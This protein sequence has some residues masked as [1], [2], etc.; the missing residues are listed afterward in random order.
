MNLKPFKGAGST[1]SRRRF[2]DQIYQSVVASRKVGGRN[3]TVDEHQGLGTLIN[4][5]DV[6]ARRQPTGQGGGGGPPP[7]ATGACCED[8]ECS[9]TTESDCEGQWQG[10]D[11]TCEDV[12]CTQATTGACCI[13]EDCTTET[14]GDCTDMGGT[15]QGDDTICDPNPCPDSC[16]CAFTAFDGSGRLF[17]TAT[18]TSTGH[19]TGNICDWSATSVVKCDHGVQSIVSCS[20]SITGPFG[21]Y[22]WVSGGTNYELNNY[23]PNY[24]GPFCGTA[25]DPCIN[26]STC[27]G[28]TVNSATN[29]TAGTG[30]LFGTGGCSVD[31]SDE[32]FPPMMSAFRDD[33]FFRNK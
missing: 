15:Y 27:S 26:A 3:V 17:L 5:A 9:I 30:C 25:N 10:S 22:S 7:V 19:C 28:F 13:G 2:W 8:G 16:S 33:P 21:T 11:T 23:V 32:C 14:P 29:Q 18:V 20:G 24:S 12:D 6:G 4:V 31:L 1:P